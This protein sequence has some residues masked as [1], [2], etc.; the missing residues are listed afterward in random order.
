MI[1]PVEHFLYKTIGLGAAQVAC[2]AAGIVVILLLR[3]V[4]DEII[5][6]VVPHVGV[7][8]VFR[9]KSL[10]IVHVAEARV[11][12]RQHKFHPFYAVGHFVFE[13]VVEETDEL[14]TRLEL[15]FGRGVVINAVFFHQVSRPR[16]DGPFGQLHGPDI[17]LLD[18][19]ILMDGS[20]LR[21]GQHIFQTAILILA[22]PGRFQPA[23][24][25]TGLGNDAR[26]IEGRHHIDDAGTAD[27][28]GLR[29]I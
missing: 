5:H 9:G 4:E 21:P 22:Y 19:D 29:D 10:G 1:E 16:V 28:D 18:G 17:S 24:D 2:M 26:R 12:G 7:L 15:L 23:V 8:A 25:T 11:V 14:S 3:F 27:A 6:I 20:F 13:A